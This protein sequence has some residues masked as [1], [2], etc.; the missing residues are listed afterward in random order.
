MPRY[1]HV[2]LHL[3]YQ[4]FVSGQLL[5]VRVDLPSLDR[6]KS[7]AKVVSVY[8][9]PSY[10]ANH[11]ANMTLFIKKSDLTNRFKTQMTPSSQSEMLLLGRYPRC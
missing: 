9:T 11:P 6:S 10:G 3:L 5:H 7:F 8:L 2:R 1:F 4:T